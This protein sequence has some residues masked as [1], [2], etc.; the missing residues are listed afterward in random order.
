MIDGFVN[1]ANGQFIA[2]LAKHMIM[3]CIN[4]GFDTSDRNPLYLIEHN[5]I[6]GAV[7]ALGGARTFMRSHGLG[8]FQS[9]PGFKIGGNGGGAEGMAPDLSQPMP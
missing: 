7:V 6:A 4:C 9:A 3:S 1:R 5:P 2:K 8:F